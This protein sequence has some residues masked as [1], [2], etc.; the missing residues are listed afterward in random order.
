[1]DIFADKKNLGHEIESLQFFVE[2]FVK[3]SHKQKTLKAILSV[4]NNIDA[5]L[6]SFM[7]CLDDGNFSSLNW[8]NLN[9][10]LWR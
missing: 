10:F 3:A 7:P 5:N 9:K 8:F 4:N 6:S 1:V 2:I